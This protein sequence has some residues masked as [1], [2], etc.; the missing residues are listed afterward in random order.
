MSRKPQIAACVMAILIYATPGLAQR[1]IEFKDYEFAIS[2]NM[3]I[4]EKGNVSFLETRIAP[5]CLDLVE[6]VP[7]DSEFHRLAE[8]MRQVES[9]VYA[10]ELERDLLRATNES[11]R[12]DAPLSYLLLSGASRNRGQPLNEAERLHLA[13]ALEVLRTDVHDFWSRISSE[14]PNVELFSDLETLVGG[15][16]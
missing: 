8:K 14:N 6:D 5:F 11:L 1:V 9:E 16:E 7:D 2:G 3:N 12:K 13:R 4:D 10:L 15:E